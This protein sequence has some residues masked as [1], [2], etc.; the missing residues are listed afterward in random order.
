MQANTDRAELKPIT[1]EVIG[2]GMRV[3]SALGFGFLEKVYENAPVLELRSRGI[4]V[5]QQCSVKVRYRQEIVGEFMTDLKV[6]GRVIV[7]VKALPAI[8]DAHHLQ[9]LNY[10]RA[11]GLPICLLLNSGR[12]RLEYQRFAYDGDRR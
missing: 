3:S 2:A 1:G 4:R 5:E 10:L 8:L 7:E 12:R 6:E 11:T 9:C